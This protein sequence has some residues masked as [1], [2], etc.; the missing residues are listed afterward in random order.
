MK[1]LN[2][3]KKILTDFMSSHQQINDVKYEDDFDFNVERNLSYPVCNIEYLNSNMSGKEMRHQFKVVLADVVSE[4]IKQH[5]DEIYSDMLQVAE[6]FFT[7]LQ[8]SEGFDFIRSTNINK[9]TDDTHDR[10][11]GIVFTITLST[12][13]L[14]NS[15]LNPKIPL[16]SQ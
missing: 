11:A 6:D 10:T 14:Q 1:T 12:I 15:C 9:F 3:I 5:E 2:Q 8:Y 4:N 13:R 7:Y 16:Q